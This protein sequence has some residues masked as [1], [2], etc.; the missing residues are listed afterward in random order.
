AFA[1]VHGDVVHR[2]HHGT[3][4][5]VVEDLLLGHEAHQP[6]DRLRRQSAVHEVRVAHVVAGKQGATLPGDVVRTHDVELL[7]QQPEGRLGRDDDGRVRDVQHAEV[8]SCSG[9]GRKVHPG[10]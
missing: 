8:S 6:L 2:A 9:G 1:A 4:H 7:T 3:T 5:R 10:A